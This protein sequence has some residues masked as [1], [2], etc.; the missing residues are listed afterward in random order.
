VCT[1]SPEQLPAGLSGGVVHRELGMVSRCPPLVIWPLPRVEEPVGGAD[2]LSRVHGLSGD[3]LVQL[4]SW[5]ARSDAA[6]TRLMILTRNAVGIGAYDGVPDLAH[7]AAW[8]LIHTAQNEYPDRIVLLDVDDSAA[9]GEA[10]RA[11]VSTPPVGEPR[12]AL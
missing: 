4:Q 11:V 7:A 10:L 6:N 8:A 3:V 1:E 12:L 5:L 9:T 2:P